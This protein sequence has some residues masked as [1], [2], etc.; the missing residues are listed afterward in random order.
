MA[1]LNTEPNSPPFIPNRCKIDTRHL[2]CNTRSMEAQF[3]TVLMVLR[4]Q[5]TFDDT[6]P[7]SGGRRQDRC[8]ELPSDSDLSP[9]SFFPSS[10]GVYNPTSEDGL[11]PPCG[12]ESRNHEYVEAAHVEVVP[13]SRDGAQR[14]A[15]FYSQDQAQSSH[16]T[17]TPD[18]QTPKLSAFVV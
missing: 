4:L 6:T 13:S 11:Q 9:W 3:L 10:S 7:I 5:S 8:A 16:Q 12:P 2:R 17:V 1:P 18:F 14:L 15:M